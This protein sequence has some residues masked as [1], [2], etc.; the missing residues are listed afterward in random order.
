M[1]ALNL[2]LGLAGIYL[3]ARQLGRGVHRLASEMNPER[4]GVRRRVENG[5]PV[6]YVPRSATRTQGSIVSQGKHVGTIAGQMRVT[7]REV[8]TLGDRLATIIELSDRGKVD[9]K[10][11]AWVRGELSKKCGPGWNGEQWCVKEKDRRGEA[12]AIFRAI[13]RDTRY[14]SDVHGLDTYAAPSTTRK[15]KAEDCDGFASLTCAA[16]KAAGMN[17]RM[18]V[19][20][21]KAGNGDPDHIF[22][23]VDIDGK[24]VPVDASTNM[25]FGWQAPNSMVRTKWVFET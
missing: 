4:A 12:E 15:T 17:C 10:I 11:I 7:T 5:I 6:I 25:G 2:V 23:E 3:G 13:R 20:A 14:Q 19:I 9:P 24:W 22:N 8:K 21:T 1:S 16:M 18:V